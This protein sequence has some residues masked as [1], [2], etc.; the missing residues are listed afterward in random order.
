MP[1][2]EPE[3][4]LIFQSSQREAFF[5]AWPRGTLQLILERCQQ[6]FINVLSK[7]AVLVIPH[8]ILTVLYIALL[9]SHIVPATCFP[10]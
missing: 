4:F 2:S 8:H 3:L 1:E 6:R 9:T 10:R 7:V 5:H